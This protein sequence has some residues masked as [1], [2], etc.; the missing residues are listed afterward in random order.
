M[1]SN[2]TLSHENPRFPSVDIH[3]VSQRFIHSSTFAKQ[4]RSSQVL[5]QVCLHIEGGSCLG[6]VGE[7]GSGKSTLARIVVGLLQPTEGKVFI[8]DQLFSSPDTPARAGGNGTIQMVFQDPFSSL[9][10]RKTVA[11]SLTE[12]L[13][14][15]RR[16][17]RRQRQEEA[18]RLL[19]MVGLDPR[20]GSRYPH[21][22]SGGQRQ[23]IALARALASDPKVLV[24]DEPVSALDV[25]VQAQVL[26]LLS[27]LT[28]QHKP[29][30]L[31][32]SHDLSVVASLAD[33]IAVI[34]QGRIV[35]I[36]PVDTVLTTPR[37]PY[38]KELVRA[39]LMTE[40]DESPLIQ[41]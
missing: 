39:C 35:E 23:R 4:A 28:V 19:E 18:A 9:S 17:S 24:L 36:G 6:L 7:S 8:D 12:G 38:T 20:S 31:F 10:P 13:D 2:I 40:L 25:S 41:A 37:H 29:T 27:T 34:H 1:A 32:I 11:W 30:M 16:L 5:N 15:A 14:L 21:E 26:Y 22:F 3:N 33:N